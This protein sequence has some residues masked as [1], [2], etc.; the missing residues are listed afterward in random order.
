MGWFIGDSGAY[1]VAGVQMEFLTMNI[2]AIEFGTILWP[3]KFGTSCN[4]PPEDGDDDRSP[5]AIFTIQSD[6][7]A[8]MFLSVRAGNWLK[9]QDTMC[10]YACHHD[11]RTLE[12]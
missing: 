1:N 7:N 6:T 9:S 11:L 12:L 3:Y 8:G 2:G 10:N 4:Y 5:G